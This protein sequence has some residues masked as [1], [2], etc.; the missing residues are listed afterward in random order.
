MRIIT[1]QIEAYINS[2]VPA[3]DPVLAEMEKIAEERDF[4]II[5]PQVGRF[6]GILARFSGARRVLELG[7]GFGY[8]AYWFA[9]AL[10]PG[11]VIHCTDLSPANRDMAQR[12]FRKA[13]LMERLIFHVG[14]AL[15]IAREQKGPFD[16]IFND[17]DKQAYPE[18]LETALPLLRTGGL[19]ITDNVLW[20][21]RVAEDGSG[22]DE[23]TQA[24]KKFNGMIFG[25]RNLETVIIPTRDGVAVCQKK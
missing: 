21:G 7:S 8:S 1:P 2:L 17:I 9:R 4:P 12:F 10:A 20:D 15:Q 19:F 11:G 14:D 24:I 22:A 25:H 3:R 6:L 13:G 18:S 23:T 16:I 5:G